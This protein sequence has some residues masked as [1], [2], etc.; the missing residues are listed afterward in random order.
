MIRSALKTIIS[1]EDSVSSLRKKQAALQQ[2]QNMAADLDRP[3]SSKELAV[4]KVLLGKDRGMVNPL[5]SNDWCRD[6]HRSHQK[7][8]TKKEAPS[9]H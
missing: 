6:L 9:L 5:E 1:L 4:M 8:F 7:V 2:V 3:L